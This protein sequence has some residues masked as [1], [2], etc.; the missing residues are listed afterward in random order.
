VILNP[1]SDDLDVVKFGAW[2]TV[3]SLADGKE[4]RY[5]IVGVDETDVAR[6]WI[7]WIS[8]VAMALFNQE[9]GDRVKVALP[10]GQREL[11]IVDVTYD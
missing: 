3:R 5:R 9:V 2:V 11:E 1:P 6:G 8:P 7:S 4:V 10:S